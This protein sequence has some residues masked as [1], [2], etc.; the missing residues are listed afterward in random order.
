MTDGHSQTDVEPGF[1]PF[2]R[3]SP[4]ISNAVGPLFQRLDG[5]RLVLALRV[6]ERHANARGLAH[7]GLLSTVADIGL[8]HVLGADGSGSLPVTVGITI[9]FLAPVRIGSWLEVHTAIHRAGS[10]LGFTSAEM[11]VDGELVARAI[12]TFSMR[13]ASGHAESP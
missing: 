1:S 6:T 10:R 2:P 5:E 8:G 13:H 9:D 7:G 3:Q 11:R 12:G 4:Y